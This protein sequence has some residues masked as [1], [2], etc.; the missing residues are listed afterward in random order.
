MITCVPTVARVCDRL[1]DHYAAH[2]EAWTKDAYSRPRYV[3][4]GRVEMTYCLV[5][6]LAWMIN[7]TVPADRRDAARTEVRAAL[8][9]TLG[10]T[11]SSDL[12]AWNDHPDRTLPEVIALLRATA[13]NARRAAEDAAELAAHPGVRSAITEIAA[14][15]R[16]ARDAAADRSRAC[17]H[18]LTVA[19]FRVTWRDAEPACE[20]DIDRAIR[21]LLDEDTDRELA[22][23]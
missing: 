11:W 6:G 10:G 1:A 2:P 16:A 18:R 17:L 22:D 19:A 20:D 15:L 7:S 21:L 3:I 13:A 9:H 14:M 8:H 5:G 4:D 12:E 23:A